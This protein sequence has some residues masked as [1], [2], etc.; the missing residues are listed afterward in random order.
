MPQIKKHRVF[1]CVGGVWGLLDLVLIFI[2]IY[3]N[4]I[5]LK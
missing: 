2:V 4:I 3:I 5:V 1:G